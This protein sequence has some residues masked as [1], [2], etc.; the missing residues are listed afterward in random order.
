MKPFG[1]AVFTLFGLIFSPPTQSAARNAA[2]CVTC[3]KANTMTEE[4][5]LS[6]VPSG[7]GIGIVWIAW[8]Q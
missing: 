6:W 8:A 7:P 2:A 1:I 4:R 5:C 3:L